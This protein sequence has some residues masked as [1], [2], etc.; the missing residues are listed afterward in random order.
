MTDKTERE[1][2]LDSEL[3]CPLD[4]EL[5]EMNL[6]ARQLSYKFNTLDPQDKYL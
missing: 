3:Y 2:M 1:K 5:M 6:K 4:V